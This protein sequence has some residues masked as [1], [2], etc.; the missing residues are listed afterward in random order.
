MLPA[1]IVYTVASGE[2]GKSPLYRSLTLVSYVL[3]YTLQIFCGCQGREI[4]RVR[5][6]KVRM[7]NTIRMYRSYVQRASRL[8]L[9]LKAGWIFN[10]E[11]SAGYAE[12]R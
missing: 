2:A 9:H 12:T 5:T 11:L 6:S 4:P 1:R 3:Y 8:F 10:Y 7:Y